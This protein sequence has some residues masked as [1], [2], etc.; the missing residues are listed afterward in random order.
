[1]K[2]WK[3]NLSLT[4]NMQQFSIILAIYILVLALMPCSD[5]LEFCNGSE[6]S[7]SILDPHGHDHHDHEGDECT[8]FCACA[9]CGSLLTFQAKYLDLDFITFISTKCEFYFLSDY[10]HGYVK[11]VWHPPVISWTIFYRIGMPNKYLSRV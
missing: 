8:P 7:H 11:G 1:M 4:D 3:I 6:V 2:H 5:K 9:C 10:S